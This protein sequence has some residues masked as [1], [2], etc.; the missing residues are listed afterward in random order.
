M[1]FGIQVTFDAH[2]PTKL[3]E[4]WALAAGYV[5]QPPP[6]GFATWE[7]F[8]RSIDLPEERWNDQSALIDPEGRGPR[9]Y[10]QRVPEGKTAKNRVHLDIDPGP[11]KAAHVARLVEA[12]AVVVGEVDEPTGRCTVLQDPEGNEFCVH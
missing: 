5:F 6:P 12:G 7:D 4:F 10:L 2:D 8:G 11:D 1:A 3:A 9:I